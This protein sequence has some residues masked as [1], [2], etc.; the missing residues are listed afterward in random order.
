MTTV[1]NDFQ[2][3]GNCRLFLLSL[4]AMPSIHL[5]SIR[6]A[7]LLWALSQLCSVEAEA[8]VEMSVTNAISADVCLVFWL[9]GVCPFELIFKVICFY[10]MNSCFDA[11]FSPSA[12]RTM[13]NLFTLRVLYYFYQLRLP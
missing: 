4:K 7:Y 9:L 12:R 5:C 10:I 13:S 3:V 1:K 2:A 6:L 11:S 8:G